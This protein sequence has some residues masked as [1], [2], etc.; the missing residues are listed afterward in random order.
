MITNLLWES[1]G[2]VNN[3]TTL[4][5]SD[6]IDNYDEIRYYGSALREGTTYTNV[7]TE[8]PV[9]PGEINLGGPYSFGLW[10]S[11]LFVLNNGTQCWLSGNSGYIN[12]SYYWGQNNS[13]TTT[14]G[15]ASYNNRANDVRPYKIVGVK[16]DNKDDRTTI[17]TSTGNVYN[18]GFTLDEQVN[19]FESIEIYASGKENSTNGVHVGK[20]TYNVQNA[21]MGC[22]T[23]GYSP[24]VTGFN[25]VLGSDFKIFKNRGFCSSSYFMGMNNNST[26]WAAGKWIDSNAPKMLQPYKIVGVK[27]IS[28]THINPPSFNVTVS[29]QTGGTVSVNKSTGMFGDIVTLSNTPASEYTFNSY[30]LT[31]SSLTGNQ[32]LIND[33]NVTAKGSFTQKSYTLTLQNDGHGTL[34]AGKTTGHKNDTTTLTATPNTNYAFASYSTTACTVNG[35]T[36]TFTGGNCT[37]KANFNLLSAQVWSSTATKAGGTTY[38]GTSIATSMA[39][40]G[41]GTY[42][43]LKFQL[44]SKPGGG[45]NDVTWYYN[46]TMKRQRCHF[47][48]KSYMGIVGGSFT[49]GNSN[50][51]SNTS[52]NGTFWYDKASKTDSWTQYKFITNRSNGDTSAYLR[53]VYVGHFGTTSNVTGIGKIYIGRETSQGAQ[54]ARN[55]Y[56]GWF[57]NWSNAAA[58]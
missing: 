25:Y 19:N 38:Q 9:V 58:W 47:G 48:W 16:Y 15:A 39:G 49:T 22:D 27:R 54:S 17:W 50:V 36:L 28:D 57:R 37:A 24:W 45:A 31:G 55:W 4:N 44:Y 43:V 18:V 46:G 21:V 8:Y 5:L 41:T 26:A 12:S 11:S 52:Y 40:V 51:A 20:V 13:T 42:A 35:N 23:Y 56:I 1:T 29:Q 7:I 2:M 3:H 32:F 53:G 6:S 14:Y 30:S 10:D 34:K 33:E